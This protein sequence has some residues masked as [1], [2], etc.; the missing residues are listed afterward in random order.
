[1]ADNPLSRLA[2]RVVQG[3]IKSVSRLLDREP[4]H[5]V[6]LSVL[7][8]SRNNGLLWASALT[9]TTGLSIVPI[10][11]LALSALSGFGSTRKPR[12]PVERR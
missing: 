3:G 5:T 9:Y 11:A 12:R 1:M 8:F 2:P 10:L 6:R 4:M 7:G